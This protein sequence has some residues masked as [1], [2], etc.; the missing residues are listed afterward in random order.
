MARGAI[1]SRRGENGAGA[2]RKS[3]S[4][5]EH[6]KAAMM[7]ATST[8]LQTVIVATLGVGRCAQ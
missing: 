1:E 6:R 7:D 8:M 3:F 4:Q 2:C 5:I